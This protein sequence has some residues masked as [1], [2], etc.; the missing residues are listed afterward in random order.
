MSGW[1]IVKRANPYPGLHR[2]PKRLADGTRKVY[3]YAWKGGPR[4]PDDFGS[5]EFARAF[6]EA[7][8]SRRAPKAKGTLQSLFDGYQ[9]SR[10]RSGSG[11]GFLDL[12]E[13]TQSDIRKIVQHRLEPAFGDMPI[14]ALGDPRVR[15]VFLEWR[16]E[17]AETA[18][19]RADY[20]FTVLARIFAWALDRRLILVNPL[21]KAGRVWHGSRR[22]MVWSEADEAAFMRVAPP[23]M[24]LAMTLALWTGQRQGD[25]L[26][27][28]WNAYDGSW[29]RLTQSK[30]GARVSIPVGAPLRHA[31]EAAP[32]RCPMILSNTAGRPWKPDGFRTA[33]R[34]AAARAGITDLTFNDLRGTAVTRL[35]GLECTHAEIGAIT[36][37]KNAEITSILESHYAATDPK[38]AESAIQKLEAGTRS[39]NQP[40]NRVGGRGPSGRKG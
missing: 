28:T 35:R 5:P 40:P 26:R 27:L 23:E 30:T 16:D 19:R 34:R 25:L 32:R 3:F 2:A 29:I 14:A 1:Q 21:E 38:L 33:W 31:L 20:E 24:R 17:R 39:P 37:H 12:A 11:R 18:P 7:Q 9:R 10:G 6:R 36:G 15:G 4:L 13:R 22:E 8:E